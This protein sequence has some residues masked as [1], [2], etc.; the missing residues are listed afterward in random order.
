MII[1][2]LMF[3]IA[4]AAAV[5]AAVAGQPSLTALRTDNFPQLFSLKQR[6]KYTGN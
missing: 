5:A 6:K 2:Q 4:V 3:G 1:S